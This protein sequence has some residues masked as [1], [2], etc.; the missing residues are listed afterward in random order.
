MA[1][2][3]DRDPF[4]P[5]TKGALTAQYLAPFAPIRA[6]A[7]LDAFN[8]EFLDIAALKD[9]IIGGLTRTKSDLLRIFVETAATFD[10][11]LDIR[12]EL[13][14]LARVEIAEG[15]DSPQLWMILARL[16]LTHYHDSNRAIQLIEH[17]FS[18]TDYPEEL[19]P[20]TLYSSR[21]S[22]TTA[23]SVRGLNDLLQGYGL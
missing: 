12:T 16:I 9:L 10:R 21:N 6:Q 3:T 4:W 17:L 19:R 11:T 8:L 18:F 23:M 5:L 22:D 14:T 15:I 2:R 1:Y 7:V 20:F 13:E